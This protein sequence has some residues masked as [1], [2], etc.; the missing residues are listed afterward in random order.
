LKQTVMA[1]EY[2]KQLH[3]A[4][5]ASIDD[6]KGSEH[7]RTAS[8]IYDSS[9]GIKIP[10]KMHQYAL[11]AG[12]KQY[13]LSDVGP[14]ETAGTADDVYPPMSPEEASHTGYVKD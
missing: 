14:D 12:G 4:Y 5:P 8:Y 13:S 10:L 11:Q 3:G 2:H 6:L 1:L 7:V 9:A